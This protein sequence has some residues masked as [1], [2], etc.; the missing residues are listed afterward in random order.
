MISI[1][2]K[3]KDSNSSEDKTSKVTEENC[4]Y[5]LYSKVYKIDNDNLTINN[6]STSHNSNEIIS[7]ITHTCGT[8]AIDGNK[9]LYTYNNNVKTYKI[10]KIWLPQTGND[11]VK[12]SFIIGTILIVIG[13]AMFALVKTSNT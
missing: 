10:N 7:N 5:K 12:Y 9:L 1:I 6:V 8:I 13:L 2:K 3:S 11:I 4:D